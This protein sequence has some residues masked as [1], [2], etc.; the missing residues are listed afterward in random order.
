MWTKQ[1]S[2]T[3]FGPAVRHNGSLSISYSREFTP[4]YNGPSYF[5]L[6]VVTRSNRVGDS[7]RCTWRGGL[8][9]SWGAVE[10][11]LLFLPGCLSPVRGLIPLGSELLPVRPRASASSITQ[12][13]CRGSQPQHGSAI[14]LPWPSQTWPPLSG[15]VQLV[16]PTSLYIQIQEC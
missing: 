4:H 1:L 11:E 7:C 8:W 14:S 5:M 3:C 9:G 2:S 6:I 16:V 13:S 15:W 12:P 10:W